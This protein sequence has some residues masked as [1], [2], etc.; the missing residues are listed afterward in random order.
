[1]NKL[2]PQSVWAVHVSVV[3]IAQF[4]LILGRNM[5]LFEEFIAS[6]CE[7]TIVSEL[8][9]SCQFKV[10]ANLSFVLLLISSSAPIF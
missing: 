5:L 9:L 3:L 6:M 7:G 1:M 8:A 4:S 10:S 2:A